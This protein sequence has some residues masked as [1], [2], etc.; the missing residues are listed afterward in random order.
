MT[1]IKEAI[2]ATKAMFLAFLNALRALR[3]RADNMFDSEGISMGFK[4]S[5]AEV[6]HDTK[7]VFENRIRIVP[8]QTYRI[9][10]SNRQ[11]AGLDLGGSG[12]VMTI[13]PMVVN[14]RVVQVYFYKR[15]PMKSDVG[16]EYTSIFGPENVIIFAPDPI[17][18]IRKISEEISKR[19]EDL[20]REAA[21]YFISES[22]NRIKEFNDLLKK[23]NELVHS[24]GD[25]EME[26]R[27]LVAVSAAQNMSEAL[28]EI[29]GGNDSVRGDGDP[30]GRKIALSNLSSEIYNAER[31]IFLSKFGEKGVAVQEELRV[32]GNF[33]L[34]MKEFFSSI[35]LLKKAEN[36]IFFSEGQCKITKLPYCDKMS[37]FSDGTIRCM[38]GGGVYHGTCVYNMLPEEMPSERPQNCTLAIY[39]MNPVSVPVSDDAGSVAYVEFYVPQAEEAAFRKELFVET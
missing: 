3:K 34:S 20:I 17:Q 36:S 1:E 6:V 30:L 27:L 38:S 35:L 12:D 32:L 26:L 15:P 11:S 37:P 24:Q 28:K 18:A 39:Y 31:G 5:S 10:L 19:N 9:F 21:D 23:A 22:R 25:Q 29:R 14:G 33:F 4:P 13:I 16:L 8:G 2:V 7:P